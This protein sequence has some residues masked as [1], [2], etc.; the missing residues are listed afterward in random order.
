[1][2]DRC[3]LR[4]FKCFRS[5]KIELGSLNIF[6]GVNG[7]GKSTVIQALLVLRQSWETDSLT[8][9]RLQL[10]GGLVELGTAGEVY[11]AEPDAGFSEITLATAGGAKTYSWISTQNVATSSEYYWE[12]D[13]G[14]PTGSS[15]L[16]LFLD[17]F[18][19][20]HAERVGPRKSLPI[21]LNDGRPLSVGRAGER[22]TYLVASHGKSR[23]IHQ[24]LALESMDRK[25]YATLHYQWELWMARLFPG[26]E[27]D[28]EIY[29]KA[30]QV[31]TGL[32]LRRKTGQGLYVRPPN[33]GFGLSYALGIIVAGLVAEPG[34]VL[35]VENPEAHLHPSAQ[36]ALGEFL[37]RVAA[38]G[39][40]VFVE[41]HSEHVINGA[42]RMVKQATIDPAA[43]RIFYF[44]FGKDAL[45]P[46]VTSIRVK[47]SGDI[48]SWPAGFFD[49]LDND[50]SVILE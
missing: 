33:T 1:M 44:A 47:H 40:Q 2:I 5:L 9:D 41:T 38:A 34:T 7:A 29:Q 18:N 37:A 6:A 49:Q 21:S 25:V 22:A 4:N 48:S 20:L 14:H 11:C 23:H 19:Y 3:E 30:D 39:V 17:P 8:R 12:L 31:R 46:S 28:S 50:L 43:I 15:S 35:I 24:Q 27:A 26:F 16:P 32:S 10:S 45:E 36:S 42:R 13:R